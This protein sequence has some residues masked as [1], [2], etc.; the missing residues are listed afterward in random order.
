MLHF[1]EEQNHRWAHNLAAARDFYST[2]ELVKFYQG[3]IPGTFPFPG[4]KILGAFW[5]AENMEMEERL[6]ILLDVL[7]LAHEDQYQRSSG[8]FFRWFLDDIVEM[9]DRMNLFPKDW[10]RTFL[11][12]AESGE[13]IPEDWQEQIA[14]LQSRTEQ[15]IGG[16][17]REKILLDDWFRY[18]LR[19]IVSYARN[20]IR[21]GVRSALFISENGEEALKK[22]IDPTIEYFGWKINR[23]FYNV[24]LPLTGFSDLGDIVQ[25]GSYGMLAD[26]AVSPSTTTEKTGLTEKRSFLDTCQLYGFIDSCAAFLRMPKGCTTPAYCPFCVGHGK[27]TM[28]F[29]IPPEFRIEYGLEEGLGYGGHRCTFL[30]KMIPAP[31]DDRCEQATAKI[32]GDEELSYRTEK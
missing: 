5:T 2:G 4:M 10:L 1:R 12:E 20:L 25:L 17:L 30:L 13:V 11:T 21:Q 29:V 14:S 9:N 7:P 32:F 8:H 27:K 18:C 26:Q 19:H 3:D 22:A 24:A 6:K 15:E 16:E 28:D 23:I 31:E